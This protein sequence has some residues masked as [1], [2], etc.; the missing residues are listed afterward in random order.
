MKLARI[1]LAVLSALTCVRCSDMDYSDKREKVETAELGPG[2]S[3]EVSLRG[4]SEPNRFKAVMTYTGAN[5]GAWSVRKLSPQS[6]MTSFEFSGAAGSVGDRTAAALED[7]DLIPNESYTF[8]IGRLSSGEFLPAKSIKLTIP[9]DLII[10]GV[11]PLTPEIL[12]GLQS[13]S[14][15]RIFFRKD[16][17][18]QTLGENID[19]NVEEIFS[20]GATLQTFPSG[21]PAT[22][23]VEGRKSG[24]IHLKVQRVSGPLQIEI[25]GERGGKGF[26]GAVGPTGA[27]GAPSSR[28]NHPV[29][30]G[31]EMLTYLI[32]VCSS[33]NYRPDISRLCPGL[34]YEEC[35]WKNH[36]G[37]GGTGDIGGT[38]FPGLPGARGGETED[39]SLEI[40]VS[41]TEVSVIY[42]SS[43]G[44]DGGDA[45]PGGLGGPGGAGAPMVNTSSAM[46]CDPSPEGR[47]GPRGPDG[48]KGSEGA[49]GLKGKL[50]LNGVVQ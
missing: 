26:S 9:Q 33:K 29:D 4:T 47:P 36:P 15:F 21:V 41:A 13:K 3:F 40:P 38:G 20:E 23:G 10:S 22:L 24:K 6:K 43:L 44:G 8:E 7:F 12:T 18:L 45:G 37:V 17:V 31:F 49:P 32:E 39:A 48:A 35:R 14:L 27:I 30:Y 19:I 28:M 2:E 34:S 16:S 25:R 11:T 1:F 42:E 50:T 5:A 46:P